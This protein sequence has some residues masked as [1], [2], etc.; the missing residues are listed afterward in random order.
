MSH[1]LFPNLKTIINNDS[2]TLE[3]QEYFHNILVN[4]LVAINKNTSLSPQALAN[5]CQLENQLITFETQGINTNMRVEMNYLV[6]SVPFL[7][8]FYVEFD[9]NGCY[10]YYCIEEDLD[11]GSNLNSLLH[12]IPINQG[13]FS[14]QFM[15]HDIHILLAP[16]NS[17]FY[18]TKFKKIFNFS[19][20]LE[21]FNVTLCY[22]IDD[23]GIIE[24]YIRYDDRYIAHNLNFDLAYESHFINF[25]NMLYS[26]NVPT[27]LNEYIITKLH[28]SYSA[29]FKYY[30]QDFKYCKYTELFHEMINN[31]KNWDNYVYCPISDSFKIASDLFVLIMNS[32]HKNLVLDEITVHEMATY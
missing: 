23:S 1:L 4:K 18:I 9:H 19:D 8:Q 13:D 29:K 15:L 14:I 22:D 12:L 24:K 25:M 32:E 21:L 27:I 16:V 5:L 30:D 28:P 7:F 3:Q 10:E 17:N 6:D 31:K 26:G 2:L 11:V 20:D